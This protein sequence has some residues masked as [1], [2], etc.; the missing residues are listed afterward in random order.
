MI[1]EAT[2]PQSFKMG[3]NFEDYAREFLFVKD[4]YDVLER[5]HNYTAN[6]KDYVES[7]LKP[8]FKFRDRYTKKEFYIEAKFRTG[9]HQGK[10]MWC[11]QQQLIRYQ[12]Y[13]KERPVF[14]LL[15]MGSDAKYPE[16]LSL[17]PL[18]HAKYTG[19]FYSLADKFEI[20]FD[21]AVTSKILWSR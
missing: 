7:S 20:P 10:I 4:Y 13:N 16:Y 9:D 18:T 3:Q 8:D 21:K 6:N 12:Q 5:T 2:T 1:D 14:L 17:I 15:G 19:L 11:N